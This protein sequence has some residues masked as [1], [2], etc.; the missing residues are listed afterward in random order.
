[1]TNALA[2][3]S[4]EETALSELR[5]RQKPKTV[6]KHNCHIFYK[7]AIKKE[8]YFKATDKSTMKRY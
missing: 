7:V 4:N 3:Y 2:L 5:R 1:M 8:T 6:K